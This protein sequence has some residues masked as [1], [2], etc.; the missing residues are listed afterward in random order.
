MVWIWGAYGV[1]RVLI[2]CGFV[3]DMLW[4]GCGYV[5]DRVWISCGYRVDIGVS[6][7]WIGGALEE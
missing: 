7:V 4:I 6:R 1:D 5:V 3:V 2:G